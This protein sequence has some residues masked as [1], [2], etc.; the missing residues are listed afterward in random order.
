MS[1]C[2]TR[3]RRLTS[4]VG[5]RQPQTSCAST[6]AT[7]SRM[8]S[9]MWTRSTW[10]YRAFKES[11]WSLAWCSVPAW[12]VWNIT[13]GQSSLDFGKLLPAFSRR[14]VE[15]LRRKFFASLRPPP[16]EVPDTLGDVPCFADVEASRAKLF[17]CHRCVGIVT[18]FRDAASLVSSEEGAQAFLVSFAYQ[19]HQTAVFLPVR[20]FQ[21]ALLALTLLALTRVSGNEALNA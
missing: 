1:S 12:F 18:P 2:S 10:S 20:R 11:A 17:G 19:T 5:T 14:S 13:I 21:L 4:R 9:T 15:S 8:C 16:T 6:L 3:F 7:S